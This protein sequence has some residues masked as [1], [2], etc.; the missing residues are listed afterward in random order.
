MPEGPET[1]RM[2]DRIRKSLIGKDI[3]HFHFNHEALADLKKVEKIQVVDALSRGKAIIIRLHNGKSIISHNQ[4]YGKWTFHRPKT[5]VKS[6]RQLRME[7]ITGTKAVR[8]WSATDIQVLNSSIE[9][10]HEYLK[11]I[12]PDILSKKTDLRI[13]ADILV[14]KKSRNRALSSVLLDQSIL[15]GIGNYL[16]SEIL[17]FSLLHHSQ[18]VSELN[19]NQVLS[20]GKAIKEVTERAY[21][22]KG[23]TIDLKYFSKEFGNID[24]FR[25]VKHMVFGREGLPCF[26]CSQI[27]IKLIV[28]S[29]RI[30]LCANCQNYS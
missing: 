20:L 1:R 30:F 29:R 13:I 8:L 25:R 2:A 9:S 19:Q 5:I 23:K 21:F 17:F 10:S 4:L 14:G 22:Q 24:N 12:G 18:K 3:L 11:K 16:R 6:N 27:I 26:I 28:S 15:S 7:F